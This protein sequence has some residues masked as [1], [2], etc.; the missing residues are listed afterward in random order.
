MMPSAIVNLLNF[1]DKINTRFVKA[2]INHKIK[3]K[4]H[5]T[6]NSLLHKGIFLYSKVDEILKT[7]NIKQFK[8]LI[9][10]FIWEKLPI[11]RMVQQ[12]DYG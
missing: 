2:P 8:K 7:K 11:D 1:N 12:S 10:A 5:I 3:S 9:K 4:S 6:A